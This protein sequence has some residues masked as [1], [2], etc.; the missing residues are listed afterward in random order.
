ML[1]REG[2]AGPQDVALIG[3]ENAVS[4]RLEVIRAAGVTEFAAHVFG[5]G[6]E[7]RART[8]ALLRTSRMN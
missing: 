5:R 7:E 2:V 1:D 6:D 3:D 4:E 8:R